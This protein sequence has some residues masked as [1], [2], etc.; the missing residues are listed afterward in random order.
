[1]FWKTL[2]IHHPAAIP[3]NAG[4]LSLMR[5]RQ[6]FCGDMRHFVITV[7]HLIKP[8]FTTS[9]AFCSVSAAE[10]AEEKLPPPQP[11]EVDEAGNL[12]ESSPGSEN[13][14]PEQPAPEPSAPEDLGKVLAADIVNGVKNKVVG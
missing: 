11:S 14:L 13:K 1:M 9:L 10:C 6:P 3:Q 8:C 7:K 2:H 4:G 5:L 12:P